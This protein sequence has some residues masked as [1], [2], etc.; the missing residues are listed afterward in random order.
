[1]TSLHIKNKDQFDEYQLRELQ[2]IAEMDLSQDEF[3]YIA[4]TRFDDFYMKQIAKGFENHIPIQDM[5]IVYNCSNSIITFRDMV[6]Y[7][8]RGLNTDY[9]KYFE[10]KDFHYLQAQKL[11]QGFYN[12]FTIEQASKYINTDMNSNLIRGICTL[13][14]TVGEEKAKPFITKPFKLKQFE[15]IAYA[16]QNYDSE[17]L[18]LFSNPEVPY[19]HMKLII[20]F[21]DH[22][23]SVEDINSIFNQKLS[24]RQLTMLLYFVKSAIPMYVVKLCAVPVRDNEFCSEFMSKIK[25]G[26]EMGLS[27]LQLHELS[28]YRFNPN[29]FRNTYENMVNDFSLNSNSE[30][31]DEIF[32]AIYLLIKSRSFTTEQ[33]QKLYFILNSK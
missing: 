28:N 8:I 11:L 7:L 4:D 22:G 29:M 26:Y 20:G 16:I 3:D 10:D 32:E 19:K 24:T 6:S 23:V 21:L 30:S 5:E 25:S 12:G 33:K 9:I 1:M 13:V 14:T 31:D 18:S 15:C 17:K 27:T 2:N